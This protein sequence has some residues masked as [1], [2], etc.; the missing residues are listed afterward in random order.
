MRTRPLC[1]KCIYTYTPGYY[2][3]YVY[4]PIILSL[5]TPAH[6]YTHIKSR[7]PQPHHSLFNIC[8]SMLLLVRVSFGLVGYKIIELI[9]NVVKWRIFYH[10]YNFFACALRT[11]SIARS[12]LRERFQSS[13]QTQTQIDT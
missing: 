3:V 11:Y 10:H 9:I 5:S 12:F 7:M 13:E 8:V 1:A 4:L 2:M 6:V